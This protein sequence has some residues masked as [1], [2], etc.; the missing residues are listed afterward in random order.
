M[1]AASR[2]AGLP[3]IPT[4][5]HQPSYYFTFPKRPFGKQNRSFQRSWFTQWKFLHYDEA[6]DV[7]FVIPV[8]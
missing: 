8:C 4:V 5:P 2:F 1:M 7:V 3:D 6:N